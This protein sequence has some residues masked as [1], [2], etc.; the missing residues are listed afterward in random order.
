MDSKALCWRKG[1]ANTITL[2]N[3][4]F[5]CVAVLLALRAGGAPDGAAEL[6]MLQMAA[7]AI[8]LGAICDVFDGFV[9][10]A[11]GVS[12]PLGIELDSLSDLVTFGVAPAALYSGV[13][14]RLTQGGA[15][16]WVEALPFVL[17]LA[18]SLR[19]AYFNIDS[20]QTVTFR[21]LPS[22]ASALFTVGLVLGLS[23]PAGAEVFRTMLGCPYAIMTWVV[24]QSVLMLLPM[25]MASFKIRGSGLRAWWHVALLGAV[26]LVGYVFFR[27]GVA[28]LGVLVYI[29]VS[30]FAVRNR[31]RE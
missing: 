26:V 24:L 31:A 18:T 25:R 17:V 13:I 4:A 10:R 8:V 15:P 2:G 27:G 1:V 29:L 28:A 5:G 6:R 30:P 3:L 9:A 23:A 7:W 16:L 22:P 19:L 20:T 14:Y 21:G 11:M 12:S